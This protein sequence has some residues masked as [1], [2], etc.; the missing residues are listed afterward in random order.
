MPSCEGT[1]LRRALVIVLGLG[2]PA[3]AATALAVVTITVT[4][5]NPSGW[6]WKKKGTSCGG[7]RTGRVSFVDGP[8]TPPLGSGSLRLSTGGNGD[9]YAWVRT[10]AYDGTSLSSFAALYY[11]T[12]VPTKGPEAP[13]VDLFVKWS[14]GS[15]VLTFEPRYNTDTDGNPLTQNT[16][17]T[18]DLLGG[19]WWSNDHGGRPLFTLAAFDASHGGDVVVAKQGFRFS[20]GC[21]GAPWNFFT[22]YVDRLHSGIQGQDSRFYDFEP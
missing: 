14:G 19:K 12:Y 5:D 3:F 16:W 6:S 22:G 18:W 9:A 1:V 2:S 17:Q 15:D 13:Y 20:V 4:P 11:S 10:G 8:A 7:G 21:G